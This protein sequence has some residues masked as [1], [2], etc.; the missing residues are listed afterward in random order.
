MHKG[1]NRMEIEETI[2]DF[3]HREFLPEESP[4]ALQNSTPLIS[5]GILDSIA[6]ARLVSFLETHFDIRF[7]ASEIGVQRMDTIDLIADTV[8]SKIQR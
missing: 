7:K 8:D 5:S 3:I 1:A 6:T 2:R 4:E